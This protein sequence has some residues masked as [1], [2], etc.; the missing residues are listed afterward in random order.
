MLFPQLPEPILIFLKSFICLSYT[1]QLPHFTNPLD[2]LRIIG[3][4]EIEHFEHCYVK[5]GHQVGNA[6]FI[7]SNK[8]LVLKVDAFEVSESR[9]DCS[10]CVLF[11]EGEISSFEDG[12]KK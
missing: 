3:I 2:N 12:S 9:S 11:V 7:S 6:R 10:I 4:V 8:L 5:E 1:I